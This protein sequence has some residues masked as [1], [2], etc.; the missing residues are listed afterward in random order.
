MWT[1][2]GEAFP[3]P[4]LNA[5]GFPWD[6]SLPCTA[7]PW[8]LHHISRCFQRTCGIFSG[9]LSFQG[10]T[11]NAIWLP[12]LPKTQYYLLYLIARG[13]VYSAERE[14]WRERESTPPWGHSHPAIPSLPFL[15]PVGVWGLLFKLSWPGFELGQPS[16]I[17]HP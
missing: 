12:F 5:T 10:Y 6:S 16:G 3:T 13:D 4:A 9:S 2:S 11:N 8:L 7:R 17:D 14:R 15:H 1:W